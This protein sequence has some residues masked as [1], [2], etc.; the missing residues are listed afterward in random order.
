MQ[1]HPRLRREA[2]IVQILRTFIYNICVG[3]KENIASS[4]ECE[5]LNCIVYLTFIVNP[6]CADIYREVHIQSLSKAH[7][8]LFTSEKTLGSRC[9]CEPSV[10]VEASKRPNEAFPVA[11]RD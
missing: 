8:F 7:L 4:V 9:F 1:I 6:V 2:N 3:L 10:G 11:L 5:R